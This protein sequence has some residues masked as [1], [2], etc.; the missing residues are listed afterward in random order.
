MWNV[1]VFQIIECFR[2]LVEG[3]SWD[4]IFDSCVIRRRARLL[5]RQIV[6]VNLRKE[7]IISEN[8]MVKDV[9]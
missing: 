5:N 4:I 9:S 1:F 2:E 6:F 7:V 8:G 3:W